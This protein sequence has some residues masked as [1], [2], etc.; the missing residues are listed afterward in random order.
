M[1]TFCVTR[2][3]RKMCCGHVRL[4]VCLSVCP[5]PYAHTTSMPS[6]ILI[7]PAVWPQ[8]TWTENRGPCPI[9]GRGPRLTSTPSFILIHSTVW[10]Q[11]DNGLITYG[12]TVLQT[13]AQKQHSRRNLV[14]FCMLCVNFVHRQIVTGWAIILHICFTQNVGLKFNIKIQIPYYHKL[15]NIVEISIWISY[16]CSIKLSASGGLR[17]QTP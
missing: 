7:H 6:G 8:R 15:T 16:L 11:T 5:R 4:S 13:V 17:P 9:W 14:C 10:P 3:R 12:R 2:R 1:I